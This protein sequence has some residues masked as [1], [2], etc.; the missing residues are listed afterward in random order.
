MQA[1]LEALKRPCRMRV[2]VDNKGFGNL[3]LAIFDGR[4]REPG[5]GVPDELW[6]DVSALA[7]RH[8]LTFVKLATDTDKPLMRTLDGLIRDAHISSESGQ[9]EPDECIHEL[10]RGWWVW[11]VPDSRATWL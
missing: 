11:Q 9:S 10:P 7:A 4:D 2:F 1:S 5:I 6:R 8:A 3:V